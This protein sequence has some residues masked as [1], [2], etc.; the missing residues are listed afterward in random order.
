MYHDIAYSYL[1]AK[2]CQSETQSKALQEVG[3]VG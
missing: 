3:Y 1:E 2:R